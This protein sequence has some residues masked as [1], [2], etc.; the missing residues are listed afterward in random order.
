[1]AKRFIDTDFYKSPFVRSLKGSLKGL[2]CFIICDCS[3]AGI[4]S[5]D[6]EIASMYIGYSVTQKDAEI[7]IKSGKA[8]DLKNG[9][10]FF[11]D[12]I[13]HQYPQGL[14]ANNPAHK[15][16]ISELKK[17]LLIDNNLK[18][19]QSPL[20][21]SKV[22]VEVTVLETGNGSGDGIGVGKEEILTPEIYPTFEDFWKLY[23]KSN[24]KKKCEKI[25]NN[26][27]QINREKIMDHLPN[28]VKSTPDK[29]FRKHP[30]TY[31]NNESWNDEI[32]N[33]NSNG[34]TGTKNLQQEAI[35]RG[36]EKIINKQ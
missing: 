23:D 33:N 20:K 35:A 36:I 22:M 24:N 11:P 27:P 14:Q 16:F 9:K 8:I 6:F 18:V 34:T 12:F 25:W 13:E 29:K 10:W 28:Y 17:F 26:I 5:V 7:F 19:L 15:N 30:Q 1:M 32:I 3:G 21:G 31:L 4:W 2:Y